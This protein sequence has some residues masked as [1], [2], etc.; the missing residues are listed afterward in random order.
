VKWGR[1]NSA[2]ASVE[3]PFEI[4]DARTRKGLDPYQHIAQPA[5]ENRHAG[6][7]AVEATGWSSAAEGAKKVGTK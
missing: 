7:E 6:G 1:R 4:L 3:G 2:K 5:R